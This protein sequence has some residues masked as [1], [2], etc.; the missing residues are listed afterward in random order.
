MLLC[1][2]DL[3]LLMKNIRATLHLQIPSLCT[4]IRCFSPSLLTS[5]LSL[6]FHLAPLTFSRSYWPCPVLYPDLHADCALFYQSAGHTGHMTLTLVCSP[7]DLH[8]PHLIYIP[9]GLSIWQTQWPSLPTLTTKARL[10]YCNHKSDKCFILFWQISYQSC[11]YT[12]ATGT[13]NLKL[14][15]LLNYLKICPFLLLRLP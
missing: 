14:F 9:L 5:S 7:S 4:I 8:P 13:T 11:V 12:F 2:K 1:L 3:E 6:R 15:S 10:I